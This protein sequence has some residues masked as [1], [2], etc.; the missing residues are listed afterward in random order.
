LLIKRHVDACKGKAGARVLNMRGERLDSM[1]M[2][3]KKIHRLMR[4]FKLMTTL[5]R[6]NPYRKVPKATQK[7]TP[8]P[9][10]LQRKFD[11]GHPAKGLLSDITYM[12]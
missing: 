11:Q 12:Q 10:L 2:N 4:A 3:P 8:C 9:N 5:R 6:A 1:V 7:P